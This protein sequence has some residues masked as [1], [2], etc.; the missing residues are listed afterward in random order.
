MDKLTD[1]VW[2]KFLHPYPLSEKYYLAA[3]RPTHEDM[4]GIY[5]VDIFDNMTLIK[6]TPGQALLEPVTPARLRPRQRRWRP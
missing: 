2:P 6:E 3:C 5:L 4:W 1:D